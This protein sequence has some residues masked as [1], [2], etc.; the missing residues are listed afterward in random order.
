MP[1]E[2][3]ALIEGSKWTRSGRPIEFSVKIE[4]PSGSYFTTI[5]LRTIDEVE[6]LCDRWNARPDWQVYC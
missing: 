1:Y 4:R 6:R 3:T 2:R 5:Y